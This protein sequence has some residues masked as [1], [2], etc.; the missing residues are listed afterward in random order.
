VLLIRSVRAVPEV[1]GLAIPVTDAV[2]AVEYPPVMR[3]MDLGIVG[4]SI[5]DHPI[6]SGRINIVEDLICLHSTGRSGLVERM[7][8]VSQDGLLT[9]NEIDIVPGVIVPGEAVNFG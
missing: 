8:I 3:R 7:I 1:G 9:L 5:G 2:E 6:A 4:Q